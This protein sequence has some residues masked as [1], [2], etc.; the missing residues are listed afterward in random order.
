MEPPK[1]NPPYGALLPTKFPTNVIVAF[2]M[3][4]TDYDY[5]SLLSISACLPG[6]AATVQKDPHLAWRRRKAAHLPVPLLTQG[7]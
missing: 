7:V 4:V 3:A 1:S 2:F 6:L 5:D